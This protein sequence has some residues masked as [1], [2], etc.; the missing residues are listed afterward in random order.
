MIVPLLV[1]LRR[2]EGASAMMRYCQAVQITKTPA[3]INKRGDER[4]EVA[5]SLITKPL[6]RASSQGSRSARETMTINYFRRKK[7]R[8]VSII[9]I[10]NE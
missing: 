6:K 8:V 7:K 3:V 4:Y 9:I 1:L 2:C 5:E 10:S